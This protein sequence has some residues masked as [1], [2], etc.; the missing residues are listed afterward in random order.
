MKITNPIVYI[1]IGGRIRYLANRNEGDP[2]LG[3]NYILQNLLWLKQDLDALGFRVS[4]NLYKR[5]LEKL[6]TE[7]LALNQNKDI[8][9]KDSLLNV[10]QKTRLIDGIMAL[11]DTLLSEAEEHV[12]ASPVPRRF[13][14]D[15]LL[16]NPGS[17]LGRGVFESLTDIAKY[18]LASSCKAIAF[19][20]PTAAAFHIL[21]CIEE[22][23]RVLYKAYFP[24]KD[25]S[26]A[27]GIL[28]RELSDKPKKPQPDE[29]ILEHLNHLRKR[30]RNPTDH[31][32]KIYEIEE[33]E[34][35]VHMAVDVINRIS[36][37]PKVKVKI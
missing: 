35:I 19:E 29:T 31:P 8:S 20:C 3:N 30:F 28:T 11:E 18:D 22:S 25:A 1:H 26:R 37:D 4:S 10:T 14:L 15:H 36:K 9:E 32:E 33:A 21:R 5:K 17:I 24:R 7:L 13:A 23:V 16:N 27:W 2:I 12:I 34:D 6:E